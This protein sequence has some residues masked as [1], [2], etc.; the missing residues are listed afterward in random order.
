MLWKYG[1]EGLFYDP[2]NILDN[3]TFSGGV[4]DESERIWKDMVMAHLRNI[5]FSGMIDEL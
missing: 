5:T 1:V 4:T 3:I 2:F